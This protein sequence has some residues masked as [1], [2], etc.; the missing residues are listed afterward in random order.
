MSDTSGVLD[1]LIEMTFDTFVENHSAN[2]LLSS[3]PVNKLVQNRCI[4]KDAKIWK[5]LFRKR[6]FNLQLQDFL[7]TKMNAREK[8]KSVKRCKQ[9]QKASGMGICRRKQA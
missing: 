7:E 1:T 6:T 8:Q 5:P 2:L 9:L 3:F 4:S